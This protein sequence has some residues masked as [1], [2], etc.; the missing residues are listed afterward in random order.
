MPYKYQEKHQVNDV[1]S[2]STLMWAWLSNCTDSPAFGKHCSK[3]WLVVSSVEL[4]SWGLFLTSCH[5]EAQYLMRNIFMLSLQLIPFAQVEEM[6]GSLTEICKNKKIMRVYKCDA[7]V[8]VYLTH[9]FFYMRRISVPLSCAHSSHWLR[10]AADGVLYID[11][12]A[13]SRRWTTFCKPFS[14]WIID[15]ILSG[16]SV[17]FHFLAPEWWVLCGFLRLPAF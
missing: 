13:H 1:H 14:S 2:F 8:S 11:L 12:L 15:R 10:Q 17:W 4:K 6:G 3:I 7:G 5:A 9:M 16:G